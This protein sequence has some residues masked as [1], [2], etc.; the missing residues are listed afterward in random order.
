LHVKPSLLT[1]FND[2]LATVLAGA[3]CVPVD[4][5]GRYLTAT[6][7]NLTPPCR[8]TDADGTSGPHCGGPGRATALLEYDGA[9]LGKLILKGWLPRSDTYSPK[10]IRRAV[11][12]LIARGD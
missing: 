7:D 8:V 12:D 5:R 1:L 4:Q 2:Q 6:A 3:R 9:G 10:A 11:S